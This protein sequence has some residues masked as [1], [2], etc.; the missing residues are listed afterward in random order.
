MRYLAVRTLQIV[1]WQACL[2]SLVE[3]EKL[4]LNDD[5]AFGHPFQLDSMIPSNTSCYCLKFNVLY[6][7]CFESC[8]EA[9]SADIKT[10]RTS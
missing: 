6:N 7:T 3:K 2:Y 10:Q 8:L 9:V 4:T 5:G 1:T